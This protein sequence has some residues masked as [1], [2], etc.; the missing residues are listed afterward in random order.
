MGALR[1]VTF[2]GCLYY[3]S[4]KGETYNLDYHEIP[5]FPC[6]VDG[7]KERYWM[8]YLNSLLTA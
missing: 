6:D 1:G 7:T 2:K 5:H 8:T 3:S 4:V